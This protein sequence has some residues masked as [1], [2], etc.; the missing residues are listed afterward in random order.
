MLLDMDKAKLRL[1]KRFRTIKARK[2]LDEGLVGLIEAVAYMQLHA[3]D[4][5]EVALPHTSRLSPKADISQGRP[6]LPLAEFPY[7]KTQASALLNEFI[8]LLCKESTP[9][10]QTAQAVAT[11]ISEKTI[12]PDE[13]FSRFLEG[14]A[15]YF[16]HWA[17]EFP[18]APRILDFLSQ[19]SL[20]P[21]LEVASE[22]LAAH[23]PESDIRLTG[24]CPVCGS[25]PFISAI[26]GTE[27]KRS[28]TCSMCRHE[29]RIR[30]LACPFCDEDNQKKLKF[31]TAREEPGYRVDTCDTCGLYIKTTDFRTMDRQE[32]PALDDL[33]SLTLDFVADQQGYKR[34]TLSAWGF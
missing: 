5:A 24:N 34:A 17:E 8:D 27:G 15:D 11:A 14:N 18:D 28:A 4:R 25:L 9:L 29:Y 22:G 23:L 32:L 2:H 30:R 26:R 33:D 3:R 19:A 16:G 21:S 12:Q 7:D 31:F 6:L 10:A 20:T 1:E 13:M